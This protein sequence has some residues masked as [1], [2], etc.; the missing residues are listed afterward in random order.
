MKRSISVATVIALLGLSFPARAQSAEADELFRQG[1]A[2]LEKM[3][4]ATACSKFSESNRLERAVGTLISLAQCEEAQNKF[5]M[6]R[7]HWQE[8]A[9]LAD[10]LQD[11]LQRG[12]AA[13]A[14]VAELDKRIARLTIQLGPTAPPSTTV[15]RDDVNL[16][17][18]SFG[19]ALPVESG[20]HVLVVSAEG[21]EPKQFD[22]ML[23]EGESQTIVVEP[24]AQLPAPPP[25][26]NPGAEV[27]VAPGEPHSET[28]RTTAF[29]LGGVGVIGIG[30]GA[31]FGLR[32]SSKWSDAKDA[33]KPGACG[34]GS[35]AQSDKDSASSA[36]TISTITFIVGGAALA[37]GIAL[38]VVDRNQRY[39]SL[40]IVPSLGGLS[41]IGSF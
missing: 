26:T 36:G 28:L 30:V 15:K 13:R 8:A 4:Y 31:V 5:V 21:Y 29:V 23:S 16:Q 7:Q 25:G 24:G 38:Y 12:P 11:R 10:A 19:S 20:K 6:A 3:D 17:S 18:A 1:R 35:T 22:L 39:G 34:A 32:A 40:K 14:K 2:A 37:T 41:A 9:D 33:C 27:P